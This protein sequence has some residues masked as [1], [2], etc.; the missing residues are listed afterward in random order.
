MEA[1]FD[2]RSQAVGVQFPLLEA[3]CLVELPEEPFLASEDL[4]RPSLRIIQN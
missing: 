2:N 4:Q 1:A 3:T